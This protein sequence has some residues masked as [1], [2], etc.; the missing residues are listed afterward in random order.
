LNFLII[1]DYLYVTIEYVN[2]QMILKTLVS[3]LRGDSFD[4]HQKIKTLINFQLFSSK[5]VL[6]LPISMPANMPPNE[7]LRL[8][9]KNNLTDTKKTK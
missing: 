4:C 5:L 3:F 1:I 2:L 9:A 6:V 8:H 7:P